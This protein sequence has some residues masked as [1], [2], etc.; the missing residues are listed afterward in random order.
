[1]LDRYRALVLR[2]EAT[3]AALRRALSAA[4]A[5]ARVEL[6][7]AVAAAHAEALPLLAAS[8]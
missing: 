6:V 1:M 2:P 3:G 5:S 4:T 7:K 8:G